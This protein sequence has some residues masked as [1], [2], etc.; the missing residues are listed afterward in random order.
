MYKS[1]FGQAVFCNKFLWC[2]ADSTEQFGFGRGSLGHQQPKSAHLK[3]MKGGGFKQ[4]KHTT[5]AAQSTSRAH[6]AYLACLSISGRILSQSCMCLSLHPP[7]FLCWHC[8]LM[9]IFKNVCS[10]WVFM[11]EG[12][13]LCWCSPVSLICWLHRTNH[14]QSLT[15]Q[16]D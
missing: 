1:S 16:K 6:A 8:S 11:H 2:L 4:L 14:W 3:K 10:E 12:P 9:P 15:E 5:L 7:Q 13:D